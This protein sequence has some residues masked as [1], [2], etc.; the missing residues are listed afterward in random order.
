MKSAFYIICLSL[1]LVSCNKDP[2]QY[3]F[4]GTITEDQTGSPLSGVEVS[5]YQKP[6]NNSVTTDNFDLAAST[7]TDENGYYIMTFDREKVIEFKLNIE[8]DD[9]F[10]TDIIL[11]SGEISS[12]NTNVVD[13][14]MGA[15]SW[16]Q[17]D[18]Q[19]NLPG[20]SNDH[21]NLLLLNYKEGCDGCAD[22]DS[23]SFLGITDTTATYASTAGQ[24]FN[25][26]Y[27]VVGVES[28]SDSVYMTPFDTTFYSINY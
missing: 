13:Y 26:T 17:F 28:L 3:T 27:I 6:F 4:E 19:N 22:A 14:Q 1:I 16:V 7:I 18:I 23:Y 11:N 9:Y 20:N 21:L 24:H 5:I 15:K 25:F 10:K 2:I 12:E 8:K